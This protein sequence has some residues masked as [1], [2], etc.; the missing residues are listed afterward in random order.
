MRHSDLSFSGSFNGPAR[1]PI[2][3]LNLVPFPAT[4]WEFS[5]FVSKTVRWSSGES[6]RMEVGSRRRG[7]PARIPE[8]APA[9]RNCSAAWSNKRLKLTRP[10]RSFW[11]PQWNFPKSSP[12]PQQ[13]EAGQ[14]S[15]VVRTACGGANARV[16]RASLRSPNCS[17]PQAA[18]TSRSTG[19][20]SLANPSLRA[21]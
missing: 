17:A 18:R 13:W 8:L 4:A 10:S 16:D 9:A 1:Q 2:N 6:R 20:I 19:R 15:L 7:R 5:R 14:L 12:P 11:K 3:R 21:G